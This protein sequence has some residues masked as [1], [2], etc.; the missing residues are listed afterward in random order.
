MRAVGFLLRAHGRRRVHGCDV[1]VVGAAGVVPV[2]AGEHVAGDVE[3]LRERRIA[4]AAL[5]LCVPRSWGRT[6]GL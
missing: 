1:V 2:L 5:G 4:L 6:L 3:A